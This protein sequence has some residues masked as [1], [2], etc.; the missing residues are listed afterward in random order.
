M[1][2][3][4]LLELGSHGTSTAVVAALLA[5]KLGL[6]LH[7]AQTIGL[8]GQGESA[9]RRA[10]VTWVGAR[11]ARKLER[12]R[13]LTGEIHTHVLE[14][15][16]E[17]AV[18]G[19]AER[20]HAALIVIGAGSV[21]SEQ[22]ADLLA[23]HSSVPVLLVRDETVFL[24]WASGTQPLR[25]L[26]AVDGISDLKSLVPLV[27]QLTKDGSGEVILAHLGRS[28]RASGAESVAALREAVLASGG[29]RSWE[30]RVDPQEGPLGARLLSMAAAQRTT[31]IV[32]GSRAMSR[33]S[34]MWDRS[35]S[36]RVLQRASCAVLC[37]P[38]RSRH[39][40]PAV[41]PGP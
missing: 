9:L 7:L 39:R 14:G 12:V 20:E 21:D 2:I 26:A 3:I 15:P 19:L 28:A 16:A 4:C 13:E 17:R 18:S 40:I 10:S 38:L 23:Q 1:S 31:L 30:I 27:G 25:V 33:V 34:R 24:N 11:L 5:N 29:E 37:V 32:V 22:R 8:E 41:A 36:R 35:V 6:P